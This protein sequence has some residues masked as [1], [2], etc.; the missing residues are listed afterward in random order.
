LELGMAMGMA[1]SALISEQSA[2]LQRPIV[3]STD[4]VLVN[5]NRS[6]GSG[7]RE[8]RGGGRR[9]ATASAGQSWQEKRPARKWAGRSWELELL[10]DFAVV[11]A[12]AGAGVPAHDTGVAAVRAAEANRDIANV[13]GDGTVGIDGRQLRVRGGVETAG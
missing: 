6:P 9:A 7:Q 1:I 12:Y 5:T 10:P 2:A 8:I 4:C 11:D 3:Y 13:G